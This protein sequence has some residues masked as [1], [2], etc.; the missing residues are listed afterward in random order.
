MAE[1]VSS[2]TPEVGGDRHLDEAETPLSPRE[3]TGRII[4]KAKRKLLENLQEKRRD[5]PLS[6][7]LRAVDSEHS[8]EFAGVLNPIVVLTWIQNTEKVFRISHVD[9]E[10]KANYAFAILVDEALVWWEATYEAL[11]GYD[12]ENLSW[13]MFKTRLLEKYCP[14]DMRIRLEK[15][16]LELKQEGKTL[17]L[18]G[19]RYKICD[20][21]INRDVLSF[22]KAIEYARKR[23]HD[24]EIHCATLSVSKL[25]RI[26][27]TTP[28]SSMPPPQ[29]VRANSNSRMQSQNASRGRG[30]SQS[31]SLQSPLCRRCGKNH[32]GQCRIDKG[33]VICY[34]CGEIRHVKPVCPMKNSFV[35]HEFAH[36]FEIACYA[37]AQPFHVDTAIV[38]IPIEWKNPLYIYGEQRPKSLKIFSFLKARKF[39]SK[40][41]SIYLAYTVDTS[42]EEKKSVNEVPVVNEYPNV[43]PDDLPVLPPDRQ[44]EFRI[45][46]VLGAA[47]IAK[48]PYRLAPAEMKEMII[49]L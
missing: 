36:S 20:F 30:R 16:L 39:I 40:G 5:I 14:L 48:T 27:R 44:V 19:L 18:E 10:D 38:C 24:L 12:Q 13:E 3:S 45:D 42:K 34:G 47:P 28:V 37:I 23:E 25:P 31:F 17:F 22:D 11:N 33:S 35:S 2:H 26:E 32:Q 43:F 7:R 1:A 6:K 46:L 29:C 4:I 49:Q 21:V 9:N 15:E 41:C 8:T